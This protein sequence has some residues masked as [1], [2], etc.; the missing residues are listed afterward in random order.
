MAV[1]TTAAEQASAATAL[2]AAEAE[3]AAAGTTLLATLLAGEADF[4]PR[5]HYPP[6]EV[7]DFRTGSQWFYH[8]HDEW[9]GGHFHLFQSVGRGTGFVHLAGVV[10]DGRGEPVELFATEP[11]A[12]GEERRG[13]GLAARLLTRFA[14]THD[15]PARATN[16]WLTALVH[17]YRPEIAALHR[18]SDAAS[19]AG[20]GCKT[21]CR[22]RPIALRARLAELGITG[23]A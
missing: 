2:V 1:A 3:L 9:A 7:A 18:E 6:G 8:R 17:L 21:S 4:R 23:R 16:A 5:G 22:R 15:W 13:A 20:D 12:T 10:L 11:G 14:V 19:A